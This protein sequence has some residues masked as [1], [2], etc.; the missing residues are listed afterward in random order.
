MLLPKGQ[1][2]SRERWQ[3]IVSW[4]FLLRCSFRTKCGISAAVEKL[5][6]RINF[7]KIQETALSLWLG[8][9][10]YN[11][12]VMAFLA[13][14]P[15]LRRSAAYLGWLAACFFISTVFLSFEATAQ[16]PAGQARAA[17]TKVHN[18]AKPVRY[19]S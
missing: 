10:I 8:T 7:S 1:K 13:M 16:G 19:A 14:T 12:R 9:R 6:N 15:T 4:A 11:P 17:P 5:H 3:T 2:P 18:T